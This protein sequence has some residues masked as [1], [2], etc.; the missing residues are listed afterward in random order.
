MGI[1][2]RTITL[3][4]IR[5]SKVSRVNQRSDVIS[6]TKSIGHL[7]ALR[8]PQQKNAMQPYCQNPVLGVFKITKENDVIK[9]KSVSA[10]AIS[11]IKRSVPTTLGTLQR[12]Q[13]PKS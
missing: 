2:V 10:E 8:I 9:H 1:K 13:K 11:I 4:A 6:A 7:N 12:E 3:E 5:S